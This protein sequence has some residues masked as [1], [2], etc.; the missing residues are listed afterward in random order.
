MKRHDRE[1]FDA[2]VIN[3]RNAS[4]AAFMDA[5]YDEAEDMA[6][7]VVTRLAAERV[8][9]YKEAGAKWMVE[10]TIRWNEFEAD[11]M[12]GELARKRGLKLLD[13]E[14]A[15]NVA[16]RSTPYHFTIAREIAKTAARLDLD[17]LM[18]GDTLEDEADHYGVT[19]QRAHQIISAKR[20]QMAEYLEL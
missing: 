7:E 13:L 9:I 3:A 5:G 6:Q 14:H 8:M 11:V 19:R 1:A 10:A 18:M 17:S 12:E 4:L 20:D 2:F 16:E 15:A